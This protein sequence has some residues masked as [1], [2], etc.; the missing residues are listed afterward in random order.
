MKI[1]QNGTQVLV[2]S[3]IK[4]TSN[5]DINTFSVDIMLLDN[6]G[7]EI[8]QISVVDEKT[9]KPQEEYTFENSYNVKDENIKVASTKVLS[10][11]PN[12]ASNSLTPFDQMEQSL[13]EMEPD[14]N[15]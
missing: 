9:L 13:E 15:N 14:I 12:Y 3:T 2:Y 5:E 10:L 1:K 7:N 11:I 8:T 4:N 6:S